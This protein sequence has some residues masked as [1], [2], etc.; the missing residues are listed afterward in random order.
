MVP[1][2]KEVFSKK[3]PS[4]TEIRTAKEAFLRLVKKGKLFRVVK[5]DRVK[6]VE[7]QGF[8]APVYFAFDDP[9]W[10]G[11]VIFSVQGKDVPEIY[12]DPEHLI[13]SEYFEELLKGDPDLK[14]SGIS[15]KTVTRKIQPD[16]LYWMYFDLVRQEGW[17]TNEI[18]SGFWLVSPRP[19]SKE[20]IT[21][22][23]MKPPM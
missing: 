5:N 12:P 14:T 4:E 15:F 16:L 21:R 18:A 23:E 6:E 17:S 11:D 3:G 2:M 19:V 7:T 20:K 1:S 22:E 13:D 9:N 10:M 8:K